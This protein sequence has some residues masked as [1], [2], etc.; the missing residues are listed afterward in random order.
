MKNEG[1]KAPFKIAWGDGTK[2][3][4]EMLSWEQPLSLIILH[5]LKARS[6]PGWR[7]LPLSITGLCCHRRPH[8]LWVVWSR[9]RRWEFGGWEG[10]T[11]L[12]PLGVWTLANLPECGDHNV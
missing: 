9:Y 3:R 11:I 1:E 4:A 7:Q 8:G 10:D 6:C 5:R 2:A 12:K